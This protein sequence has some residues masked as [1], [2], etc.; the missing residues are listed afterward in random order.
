MQTERMPLTIARA[1]D[2][3]MCGWARS[4][5]SREHFGK[6]G[7]P[8]SLIG[9]SAGISLRTGMP[10]RTSP[11]NSATMTSSDGL[12]PRPPPE[13]HRR[14]RPPAMRR[15]CGACRLTLADV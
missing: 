13:A 4:R 5:G 6:P 12:M 11:A 2:H 1:R 3:R 14:P 7:A 15:R 9:R 10:A 8:G